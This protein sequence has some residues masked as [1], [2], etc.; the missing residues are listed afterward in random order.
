MTLS[1]AVSINKMGLTLLSITL[2]IILTIPFL[3]SFGISSIYM[4]KDS[5][6]ET[7]PQRIRA[8]AKLDKKIAADAEI[9]KRFNKKR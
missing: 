3:I 2:I 6:N 7:D 4:S 1:L 5:I 9:Q 8:K